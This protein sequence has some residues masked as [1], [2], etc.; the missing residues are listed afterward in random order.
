[1]AFDFS[2][3]NFFSRLDA[4]ARIFLIVSVLVGVIFI[5]YLGTRLLGGG[6]STVGASRVANAPQGLQSVPGGQLTPEYYQALQQANAQA[7]QQAQVSGTSAVPTL[8]NIGGQ[9]AAPTNTGCIICTEEDAN[10]KYQLDNWVRQGKITPEVSST[11]QQLADKNVSV[12]EYAAALDQLVKEGKLTPEQARQLLDQYKKQHANAL[13]QE[14]GKIMDDLIKSGN[15]PLDVA[16]ELL[17]A[18]KNGVSPADYAA[19]LQELVRQG[20]ISPAVAQ[21]LL[22]QYTQQKSKQIVMMSITSL[23]R[24]A[25]AGEIIP[26]VENTLVDLEYRM[27]PVDTY[28]A[29]LQRFIAAGKLTPAAA[30]KIIE[31]YR[32]QKTAIG[33]TATVNQML[34]EAEAAAYGEL[35]D[36]MKEGKM[37]PEVGAQLAKLIQENIPF[38]DYQAVVNQLLQQKKLTPEI[39]KLKIAD[40]QAV[41]GL[42]EM[43][44]R[45]GALQGNN[46]SLATYADELKR[47][48]QA[49]VL[50]PAQAA[51]LMDE[52][53]AMTAKSGLQPVISGG[54]DFAKLQ[55]RVQQT[56]VSTEP[57]MN[58]NQFSAAEVE[59]QAAL[60]SDRQSR[61]Q[62]LMTAM[63]SQA[64][65][66]VAAWQPQPME[67]KEGAPPAKPLVPE[68]AAANQAGASGTNTAAT[69][70]NTPALIKAGTILFAVLDTQANS[71]YPDSPIM[72]TIVDGKYKGAKLLGKLVTAKS[73]SGQLDRISLNFTLMNKD[74]WPKSKAIT[75]YAIDPDTA[76]LVLA[77]DVDYHYLKRF[78]AIMA[79]SFVQGYSSAILNE[80][81][82]TTGI[83]G[84]STTNPQ[85]SPGNKIAVGIGQIGQT[86]G[87]VTQ[88]YVNIPP[89]V[90]VDSGVGLGI[91]FMDDLT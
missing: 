74:E 27:V 57:A 75:A 77:S 28:A 83:F 14:S 8:I 16:N 19:K 72:A 63:S 9:S 21:Q 24:M 51:Q 47:A 26:E 62:A 3:L 91:L 65:Q 36:L 42:R 1:M 58:A 17:A 12:D 88:N 29:T 32:G 46:A 85:L 56:G 81:T 66:L 60:A 90:K 49:G 5:I 48:V 79:T 20:K 76:R 67:H 80:G 53:A 86:L 35:N 87:S 78:G 22:A 25:R 37:T 54:S 73:V 61:I 44:Q 4:R 15:L 71:D 30:N 55:A 40:Y 33:P 69:N 23:H 13:L 43:E 52:Y 2:K 34:R 50:T 10:V 82:S 89:T 84:T 59:A 70:A 7:A 11:L 45:L 38:E 68:G 64:G 41:K 18:Q 31:E 6:G 39:A